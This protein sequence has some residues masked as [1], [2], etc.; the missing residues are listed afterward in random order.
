MMD[1][2]T[3]IRRAVCALEGTT[4]GERQALYERVRN[5]LAGILRASNQPRTDAE[6]VDECLALET[7]IKRS[8]ASYSFLDGLSNLPPDA[9]AA[10]HSALDTMR[11]ADTPLPPSRLAARAH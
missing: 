9:R 10:L 2:D 4:R 8:E 1:Y 11:R 6:I 7:A 3:L 5:T